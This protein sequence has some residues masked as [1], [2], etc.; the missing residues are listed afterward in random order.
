MT[1][2]QLNNW[3]YYLQCKYSTWSTSFNNALSFGTCIDSFIENNI[4]IS[5]LFG[6]LHRYVPFTSTVTNAFSFTIDSITEDVTVRIAF[7]LD[8]YAVSYAGTD[9][10]SSILTFI[11][12]EINDNTE[13]V[14]LIV[15]S[16]LYIYSYKTGETFTIP[17]ISTTEAVVST[18]NLENDLSVI[19]NTWNC[20]SLEEICAIKNKLNSLLG[21]CKCN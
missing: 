8:G 7:T 1:Q 18:V 17:A 4:T 16:S 20:L 13:Y 6:P 12:G 5:N 9:D 10:I 14:A 2:D 3:L 21:N 11:A 19:L 15:G